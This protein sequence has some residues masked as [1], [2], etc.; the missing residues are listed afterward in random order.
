MLAH[1][2]ASDR[3]DYPLSVR[4]STSTSAAFIASAI[5]GGSLPASLTSADS[6]RCSSTLV[7]PLR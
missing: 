7:E 6:V 4:R 3:R 1:H 5:A 2:T